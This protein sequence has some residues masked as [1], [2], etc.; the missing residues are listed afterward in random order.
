MSGDDDILSMFGVGDPP[1][2]EEPKP[3]AKRKRKAKPEFKTT[4]RV[5]GGEDAA[6]GQIRAA[7][8]YGGMVVE[9]PEPVFLAFVRGMEGK[10]W[11]GLRH[12][13]YQDLV[14]GMKE[15]RR[16]MGVTPKEAEA[17]VEQR[18]KEKPEDEPDLDALLDGL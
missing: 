10:G 6:H 18:V 3:K 4:Q 17:Q 12:D 5:V 9:I 14:G 8:V 13:E 15:I 2:V 7:M 1:P 16:R 11:S